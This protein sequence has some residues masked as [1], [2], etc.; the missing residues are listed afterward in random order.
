MPTL[1]NDAVATQQDD[2][3]DVDESQQDGQGT[4][5][6]SGDQGDEGA[7]E[8]DFL[9]V[10]DR[11]RY[12][13]REEAIRAYTEAG[14]RIAALSQW[15]R[16]ARQ[17]GV[18]DPALLPQLFGELVQ[19]RQTLQQLQRQPKE[20]PQSTP[21]P[22]AS[23]ANLTKDEREALDWLQKTFPRLGVVTKDQLQQV[24]ERLDA[25][26]Q[27]VQTQQSEIHDLLVE[28][29]TS[30][31]AEWMKADSL[32]DNENRSLQNLI[33]R[34]ITAYINSDPRLIKRWQLGGSSTERVMREAYDAAMDALSLVRTNSAATYS[35]GKKNALNRNPKKLP[36]SG[37][38]PAKNQNAD[39][40]P[41][42]QGEEVWKDAHDKAW[43]LF[44][45]KVHGKNAA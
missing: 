14:Q 31:V 29:S 23:D 28:E 45:A 42:K 37:L 11:Q 34:N 38:P 22:S 8:Q 25:L 4:P 39:A 15:E 17:Y 35:Q 9:I 33:E 3:V 41:K 40:Q 24:M 7:G 12:K 26:D 10:N 20:A 44:Q 13:T 18:D 43:D 21:N 1:D 5:D 16:A 19:A 2:Q 27:G 6:D 32:Q 36:Q 30:K